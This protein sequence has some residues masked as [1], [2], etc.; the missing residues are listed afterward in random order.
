MMYNIDIRYIEIEI[1]YRNPI[2]LPSGRRRAFVGSEPMRYTFPKAWLG[3][4]RNRTSAELTRSC[5]RDHSRK[6]Q[7]PTDGSKVSFRFSGQCVSAR[8]FHR[9]NLL[10]NSNKT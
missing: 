9:G 2:P 3:V 6:R 10:S 1:R 4:I 5:S 7:Y 8:L